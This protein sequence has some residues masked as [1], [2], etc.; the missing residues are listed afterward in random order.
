MISRSTVRA[1]VHLSRL[2]ENYRLIRSKL[3]PS[4]RLLCVVKANAY[5]HGA[6][7]IARRLED[8]GADYLGVATV[9]EGLEL[10]RSGIRA[11][12]LVMGGLFPWE[13][14]G[15]VVDSGLSLV[16]HDW[17]MLNRLAGADEHIRRAVK[18]HIKVDTGMGRLGFPM[19]DLSRVVGA[20]AASGITVEGTMSHFASSERRDTY[21]ERQVELF[22]R[23]LEVLTTAGVDPGIA[24]MANSGA[25]T[26]YP[27]AH[28]GMV[29]AGISLYGSHPDR[30]LAASLPV[31]Q[32]MELVSR[33]ALIRRFPSGVSLSYGSTFTTEATTSVA[34]V[35]VGY[36]A[37]YARALSN[38][39]SV[40]IG[41][42]R[43]HV[44]GRVC[45]DWLLVDVTDGAAITAGDEV[46]L[47][48]G[49][50][51]GA[52]TA[53]ELAEKAGTIPYEILCDISPRIERLY[54]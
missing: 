7:A 21:G 19:A 45:M 1:L 11:P 30:A 35:P 14:I 15:P 36:S 18:T 17:A 49:E 29:R 22:R 54:L 33:I 44:V 42:K 4:V 37:G 27:E 9:D 50:G 12:I 46:T 5:G 16:V 51:V 10:R 23:A 53:D 24:H 25:I 39:A 40:L 6:V 28:F 20:V 41:G 8:I 52:I 34:Y 3:S 38:Q 47:L 48:G 31:R 13:E 43:Y 26:M 2:D 32:V